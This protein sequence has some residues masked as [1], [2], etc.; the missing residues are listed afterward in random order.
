MKQIFPVALAFTL[1]ALAIPAVANGGWHRHS[2]CEQ[3]ASKMFR[4][5]Q[6]E[7][8][9]E[10]NAEVAKCINQTGE[11][12]PGKWKCLRQAARDKHENRELCGDQKEARKDVCE[13]LGENRYGPEALL[14]SGNFVEDPEEGYGEGGDQNPYFSLLAGH[15]SVARAGDFPEAETIV[16]TVTNEVREIL[17][18]N[19]RIV[20]DVVLVQEEEG[21]EYE[22]VEVT[23]DYYAL[24]TNGD[25]QY[26]GEVARNFE[27]GALENLDGSFEAGRDLA[28][29]GI[30]TKAHPETGDSHRQE[31]LLG[32]A[33]DVIQYLAGAGDETSVGIDPDE[34]GENPN[35]PCGG[36]CV[37]TQEFIPPE[38]DAGEF[39]Y[40][41]AGTGFVLGVALEDG[42]PTGERDEVQC[43]K[44]ALEEILDDPAACGIDGD[45]EELKEQLCRLSPDAFEAF[46]D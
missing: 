28:K 21:G 38:P 13:L 24:G 43:V 4:S 32:E 34:G 11:D 23:D 44:P 27:D 22:A 33:E 31:Y 5:C 41:I 39:K 8:L 15:T 9:E 20:V 2:V 46:C 30:L 36:N 37:K 3:S 40:F 10:Y 1:A 17:G 29:S 7:I 45:V 16:V 12:T 14:T 35:F 6:F 19:C 42:E 26:C 25:V 18:V